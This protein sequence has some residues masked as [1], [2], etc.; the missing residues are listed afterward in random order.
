MVNFTLLES[1]A[2]PFFAVKSLI[3]NTYSSK[4]R[5]EFDET[6]YHIILYL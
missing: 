6:N 4:C 3:S 2:V 5:L 1:F